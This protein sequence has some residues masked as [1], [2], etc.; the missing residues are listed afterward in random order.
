MVSKIT[1]D[2]GVFVV[3]FNPHPQAFHDIAMGKFCVDV[4]FRLNDTCKATHPAST[5]RRELKP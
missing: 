1:K 3:D 2:G 5:R 4:K